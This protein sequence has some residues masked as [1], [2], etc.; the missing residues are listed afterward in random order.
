[1]SRLPGYS[2]HVFI[3]AILLAI[4]SLA[5]SAQENPSRQDPI[6]TLASIA[7]DLAQMAD[8]RP[9]TLTNKTNASDDA[10]PD[11]RNPQ[12]VAGV[13]STLQAAA[14]YN[15]PTW[16]TRLLNRGIPV[17]IADGDGR[18]ALMFAAAFRSMDVAKLLLDRG[19]DS[20]ARDNEGYSALHY[21][22]TLGDV[23]M[24]TLL[25]DQGAKPD[26]RAHA[27]ETPLHAAALYGQL[28]MIR[29]LIA[30]GADPNVADDNQISSLQYAMRRDHQ[31]AVALLREFGARPDT[32]FDAVNAGDAA[33]VMRM[34][35]AGA[36]VNELGLSGTP[37][38]LA[39][40][41]GYLGIV[42]ILVDAGADLEA[43]GDPLNGTP[44]HIAALNSQALVARFL[45]GRGARVDSRDDQGR[46]PLMIVAG[47]GSAEFAEALLNAGASSSALDSAWHDSV[48]H[49][50]ACAGNVAVAKLLLAQGVDVN[51]RN[52]DSGV[53]ALHY[54]TGMGKHMM[55]SYLVA[56][57][58]DINL[59]DHQG[60]TPYDSALFKG[61][62]ATVSLLREL[63]AAVK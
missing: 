35:R 47:F 60:R 38:H 52:P 55:M 34:V 59:Q 1:M 22:A 33:R 7:P 63:G 24:A 12:I 42:G 61:N 23:A 21:A 11:L 58:A 5:A 48:L 54:A 28:G 56:M 40:A 41:K 37:L 32:L 15:R 62:A 50:A 51:A 53:T 2:F 46:T 27:G 17:D 57:G 43:K 30:R 39:A 26:S 4:G 20:N 44:L 9:N 16:A 3:S 14:L 49:W 8:P 36:D 25:L 10:G 13:G 19:A 29:L 6:G 31:P 45:I 18:T